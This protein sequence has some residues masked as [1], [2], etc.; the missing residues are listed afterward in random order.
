V[1]SETKNILFLLNNKFMNKVSPN[2]IYLIAF[3]ILQQVNAQNSEMNIK[4]PE[5][6][7]VDTVDSYFNTRIKDPYRWLEDD[8]SEETE[9]WVK[10]ENDVTFN[11][12]D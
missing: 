12:L 11:Y 7:K 9:Q 4:Y 3:F 2:I 10:S 6:K 8:R 1:N 5:T